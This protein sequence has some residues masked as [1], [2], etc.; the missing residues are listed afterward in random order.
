MHY[1][2]YPNEVT[3]YSYR[4][5]PVVKCYWGF[6]IL[7]GIDMIRRAREGG[8]GGRERGGCVRIKGR[9]WREFEGCVYMDQRGKG[10]YEYVDGMGGKNACEY[11]EGKVL[12]SMVD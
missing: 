8:C 5:K 10:G 11:A 6:I 7:R 2:T 4:N 9:V 1:L 12:L 3:I